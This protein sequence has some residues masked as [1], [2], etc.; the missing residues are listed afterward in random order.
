MSKRPVVAELSSLT[1]VLDDLTARIAALAEPLADGKDDALAT[2]LFEVERALREAGR[3]L[4]QA[5]R[6]VTGH[7]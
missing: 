6:R 1:T 5:R 4:A 7:D 3:R 2:D